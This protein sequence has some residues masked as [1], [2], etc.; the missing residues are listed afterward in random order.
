M[1][2]VFFF[3]GGIMKIVFWYFIKMLIVWS[4]TCHDIYLISWFGI[5]ERW[6]FLQFA[7]EARHVLSLSD[8]EYSLVKQQRFPVD[9]TEHVKFLNLLELWSNLESIFEA[10]LC[11]RNCY[12]TLGLYS[13][14]GQSIM[15]TDII[16]C[17]HS[18]W[19]QYFMGLDMYR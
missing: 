19:Y 10:I 5:M 13:Q 9:R 17:Q 4:V 8:A 16:Y 15:I 18:F 6:T 1:K 14:P 2:I 7:R 11:S 12:C 3:F